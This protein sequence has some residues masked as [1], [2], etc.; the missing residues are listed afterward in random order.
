MDEDVEGDELD[1][2]EPE[3]AWTADAAARFLDHL[4]R[5][6][7]DEL[8]QPHVVVCADPSTGAR[9]Y[10]GPYPDALSA[11]VAAQTGHDAAAADAETGAGEAD[12]VA[13]LVFTVAPLHG[14]DPPLPRSDPAAGS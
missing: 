4:V 11:A 5:A 14:A 7:V 6:G 12:P 13:R 8:D 3:P 10:L 9:S 2:G 1:S